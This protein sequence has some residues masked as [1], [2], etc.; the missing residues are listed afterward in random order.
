LL[1]RAKI[2]WHST[3]FGED[4]EK[5]PEKF[6]HFGLSTLEAMNSGLVPVVFN[7][8]GQPE[9][10]DHETN[11]FVWNTKDELISF[12]KMIIEEDPLRRVLSYNAIISSKKFSKDEFFK[13]LCIFLDSLNLK[14]ELSL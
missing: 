4:L 2:Y 7:A 8:G 6:E 1:K 14:T 11:G 10:V 9:L 12:T 3:G 13:K 5:N